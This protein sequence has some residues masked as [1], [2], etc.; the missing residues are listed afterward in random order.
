VILLLVFAGTQIY[1]G[2]FDLI[3][4]LKLAGFLAAASVISWLVYVL[5]CI[6]LD[7]AFSWIERA[8]SG[9]KRRKRF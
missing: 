5:V 7:P 1:E 2:T 9:P 8:L 6:P 4:F 3:D